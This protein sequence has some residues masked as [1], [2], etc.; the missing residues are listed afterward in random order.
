MA[1]TN[2][3]LEEEVK[4][5]RFREDLFFRLNVI[6]LTLPA[7]RERT[8]DLLPLA[9]S[10]LHFFERRQGRQGFSFSPAAERALTIYP[11]PGN[12][13]EL[14]NAVERAVILA[15]TFLLE[16]QDLGLPAELA[17]PPDGRSDANLLL[18]RTPVLGEDVSLAEIEREHIA[19]VVARGSV[20]RRRRESWGYRC[21]NP[22][23]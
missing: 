20:L 18:H 19:R 9:Q 8:E 5:G 1:A 15:P 13:R 23:A 22:P 7:L 16:P 17:A 14:R 12:M 3:L 11:W 6:T 21:D 2:R 4:A 10:Y